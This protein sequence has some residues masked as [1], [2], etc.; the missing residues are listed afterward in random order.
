MTTKNKSPNP[1]H[2]QELH[3][4]GYGRNHIARELNT[5]PY[6]IDKIAQENG[7]TFDRT[8]TA[9]AV[10]A[11]T[12]DAHQRRIQLATQYANAA[13]ELLQEAL[14]H[15]HTPT[16]RRNAVIASAVCVDKF[17]AL[18]QRI[19]DENNALTLTTIM[20]QTLEPP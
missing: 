14:N 20:A 6:Y 17:E 5:T 3:A 15:T 1:Q 4:K 12:I 8:H 18:T 9:Q 7:L 13:E 19:S 10:A 2:V 16:E 11:K